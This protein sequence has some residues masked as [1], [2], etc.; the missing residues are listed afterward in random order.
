MNS[1]FTAASSA[2]SNG[3]PVANLALRFL[4]PPCTLLYWKQQ[5]T[6]S[7]AASLRKEHVK[8]SWTARWL[9]ASDSRFVAMSSC[10]GA[11]V[12]GQTRQRGTLSSVFV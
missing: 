1:F 6:G 4:L 11:V 9:Q 10:A 8:G 5:A 3:P 12:K 7:A 2:G